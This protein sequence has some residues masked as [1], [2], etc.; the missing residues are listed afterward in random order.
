[1]PIGARAKTP[2]LAYGLQRFFF[3]SKCK[4]IQ[5]KSR[6][7]TIK[8]GRRTYNNCA[9]RISSAIKDQGALFDLQP[10]H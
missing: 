4:D 10:D 6:P 1:V 3:G 2:L 5:A 7:F 8:A 9:L